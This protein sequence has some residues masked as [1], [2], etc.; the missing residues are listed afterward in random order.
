MNPPKFASSSL[1]E[2]AALSLAREPLRSSESLLQPSGLQHV[3]L[4]CSA[5]CK[6][7]Y[8][9][10]PWILYLS[11]RKSIYSCE[12]CTYIPHR[13]VLVMDFIF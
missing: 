8:C 5:S 13:F 4:A 11:N 3:T 7:V 10:L 2:S 9:L 12:V 1:P 6:Y